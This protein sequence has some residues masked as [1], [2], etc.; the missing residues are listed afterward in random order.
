MTSRWP[1]HPDQ[2][3]A[4]WVPFRTAA[5]VLI[6]QS[7]APGRAALPS[8]Q[9]ERGAKSKSGQAPHDA[10]L[11]SFDHNPEGLLVRRAGLLPFNL[12]LV[13]HLVHVQNRLRDLF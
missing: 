6:E 1:N 13:H 7:R 11:R 10:D 12:Q 5:A 2:D 4:E 3:R 8:V 9:A